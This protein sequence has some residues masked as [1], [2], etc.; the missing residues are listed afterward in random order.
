M[1]GAETVIFLASSPGLDQKSGGYYVKKKAVTSSKS[2]YDPDAA[3]A[4]WNLSLKM[5]GLS[6]SLI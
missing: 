5:C 6:E 4:L 2:S 3:I 1:K